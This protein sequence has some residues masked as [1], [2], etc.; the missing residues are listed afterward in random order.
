M[1]PKKE[2]LLKKLKERKVMKVADLAPYLSNRLQLTRMADAGEIMSLRA[3]FYAH[4]SIDPLVASTVV[5]TRYYPKAV[6]SNFTALVIHRL[7]DAQIDK[8]DVDIE[9]NQSIRNALLRVHR[10]PKHRLTGITQVTYQGSRVRAYDRERSLCEA[11]LIDGEGAVFFK[12]LKRYLR[13]GK[14]DIDLIAKYDKILKTDVLK[15][16][17]QELADG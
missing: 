7:S 12:A 8:I 13:Q 17:R 2:N 9:R 6:L 1:R 5:A 16:L 4:P 11:Y 3:G 10:V 14:E 15:R